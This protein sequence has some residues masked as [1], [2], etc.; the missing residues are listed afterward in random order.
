MVAADDPRWTER[1]NRPTRHVGYRRLRVVQNGKLLVQ[2]FA[3]RLEPFDPVRNAWLSW[4]DPGGWICE[5]RDAGPHYERWQIPLSRAG[6]FI[7][8]DHP[9]DHEVDVPF[10]VRHD[11]PHQVCNDDDAPRLSLIVDRDIIVQPDSTPLTYT[12]GAPT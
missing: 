12:E 10:R 5:H 11:L 3:E 2:E 7:Q 8:G 4:L 1:S 6:Q 9:I